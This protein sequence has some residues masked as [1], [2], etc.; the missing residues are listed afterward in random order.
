[1]Q[2][3]PSGYSTSAIVDETSGYRELTNHGETKGAI[4]LVPGLQVQERMSLMSRNCE[5]I[6]VYHNNRNA[7]RRD[8]ERR[9][10][11]KQ[12]SSGLHSLMAV[13]YVLTPS[14]LLATLHG[15]LF[16]PLFYT[17]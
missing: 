15:L 8:R 17:S 16:S 6:C 10:S 14:L 1:M 11:E 13:A 12:H 3:Y 9:N 2:N 7:E 4:S 5:E